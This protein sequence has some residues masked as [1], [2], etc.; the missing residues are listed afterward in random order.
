MPK[1]L[2]T[3]GAGFIGSHLVDALVERGDSVRVL[4]DFTTGSRENLADSQAR[5]E[6]FAGSVLDE[7]LLANAAVG[8]QTVFHLAAVVSVPESLSDP[9]RAHRVNAEGILLPLEAARREGARFVLAS[10]AAVYGESGEAP[11]A[12]DVR[13]LPI[14]P[15]G[16]QKLMGELYLR[17]W[18]RE[19]GIRGAALRFFNV[20]GPR[21]DPGSPYSGVIS[22]F[23]RRALDGEPIAVHG[24]GGQTRD[25]VYVDD[26]VRALLYAER[27]RAPFVVAN[28]CSGEATELNEL[29]KAIAGK[30]G[31][32]VDVR[33]AAPRPGDIRHSLGDP[34][35][36]ESELGF[37]A[38][39]GLEE[40][41]EKLMESLK[42]ERSN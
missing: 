25:F 9:L 32:E 18:A 2:V 10:S 12:E 28:V 16:A 22:I 24:D 14:S 35:L 41:I 15:Y 7:A 33:H 21:Q 34:A 1:A 38:E 19:F 26:V 30:A 5:I 29:A 20:Y 27:A 36:A 40:G 3:G 39:I 17:C 13:A 42:R 6:V 23:A 8:C 4:D 37:R 11:L 31:R